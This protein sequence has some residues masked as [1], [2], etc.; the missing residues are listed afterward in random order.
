MTCQP[1]IAYAVAPDNLVTDEINRVLAAEILT[2]FV[3]HPLPTHGK[4][5]RV[6]LKVM[7]IYIYI[8]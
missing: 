6:V 2:E 5:Y 4:V 7:A 8:I 1:R 3:I